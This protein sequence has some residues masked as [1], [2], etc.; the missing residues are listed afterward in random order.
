MNLSPIN[1]DRSLQDKYALPLIRMLLSTQAKF[2]N[3]CILK[4][5]LTSFS[6]SSSF[7]CSTQKKYQS[8]SIESKLNPHKF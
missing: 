3:D 8:C 1:N 7:C 5:T 2:T 4:S 6:F